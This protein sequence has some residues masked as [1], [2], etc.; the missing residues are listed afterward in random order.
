MSQTYEARVNFTARDGASPVIDSGTKKILQDYKALRMEQRAVRGEFE[1]NNRTLVD[2]GRVLRSI[3]SVASSLTNI[4]TKYNVMMLRVSDSQ[5]RL[6]EATNDY[7]R[8]MAESGPG[9]EEAIRAARDLADAKQDAAR[10]Q[11]EQTLGLIGFG[12]ELA[13]T[14]SLIISSIPRIKEFVNTIRG[15][16]EAA[17]AATTV[18]TV[19]NTAN[20]ASNVASATTGAAGVTGA[21]AG[22]AGASKFTGKTGAITQQINTNAKTAIGAGGTGAALG[23]IIFPFI[24]QYLREK[25]P[26]YKASAERGE[27]TQSDQFES[28][29]NFFSGKGWNTN[30]QIQQQSIPLTIRIENKADAKVIADSK[31]PG[32]S[33]YESDQ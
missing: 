22:I 18:S 21:A 20:A 29:I 6:R 28:L 24:D 19:A 23:A 7:N 31:I 10:A 12:V 13:G 25:F 15:A 9:S 8:A 17:T 30:Q 26:S 32:V 1:L 3:G 16:K 2:A 11:Q 4:Y 33:V 5:R 14:V 27:K